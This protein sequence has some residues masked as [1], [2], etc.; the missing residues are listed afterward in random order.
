[1]SEPTGAPA[2]E[3]A[4]DELPGLDLTKLRVYL[5][6][7]RPGMVSG[8][9][10]GSVIAGGRSNLTYFF[11]D[12]TREWV[13]R[14]PPLG[15][16]LA[17]AH[18]M[19]REFRVMSGLQGTALPVP[20]TV[21]LCDDDSVLGAPFYVMDKVEGTVFRSPKQIGKLSH[22]QAHQL[23]Y[24]LID[25]L[26]DLHAVG[27]NA[28][29]LGEFGRPDGYLERQVRRWRG[30]LDKSRS[31]DVPGFDEL[32]D[33]LAASVPP[34]QKAVILHGDFRLDNAIVDDDLRIAAVLDWEMSTL[35]DP[36]ADLGLTLVYGETLS[37]IAGITPANGFAT[38]DELVARYAERTGFDLS[39]L[40]WHVAFGF[41]K[42]AVI[43]EGIHYRYVMGKTVGAGFEQ[44]GEIV[45]QLVEQGLK[46][47]PATQTTS[48]ES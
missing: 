24:T 12:G 44:F 47:A 7:Q 18:D 40:D 27:Y 20:P 14:R 10:H 29:G 35:G 39:A 43:A 9:L 22:E 8:P 25:V 15:H 34:S 4:A 37:A 32:H 42:L 6:E 36:L 2:T 5:A 13:L 45:P 26:A 19:S 31:R 46:R 23:S 11:G 41:Y 1:V 3:P 16:V 48:G 30:Q 38:N 28:V 33:K 17:T 21:L